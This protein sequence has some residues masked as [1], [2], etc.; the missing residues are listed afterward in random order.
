MEQHAGHLLGVRPLAA[1]DEH[2]DDICKQIR[3][4]FLVAHVRFRLLPSRLCLS[5]HEKEERTVD[6]APLVTGQRRRALL[7]EQRVVEALVVTQL[8]DDLIHP[9][10]HVHSCSECEGLHLLSTIRKRRTELE[11][12]VAI[13]RQLILIGLKLFQLAAVQNGQHRIPKF[14]DKRTKIRVER[15]LFL[16]NRERSICAVHGSHDATPTRK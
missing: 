5:R 13:Q 10:R 12:Q 3:M 16:G 1:H 7:H 14:L 11:C 9:A 4:R 15:W 2:L 6:D 8:S